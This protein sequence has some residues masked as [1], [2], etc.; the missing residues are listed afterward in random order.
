MSALRLPIELAF[1]TNPANDP[2]DLRP[3]RLKADV[4]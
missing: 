3:H 4:A 2:D 1:E